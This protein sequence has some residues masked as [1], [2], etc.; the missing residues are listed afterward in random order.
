M[1][2][3]QSSSS[4]CCCNGNFYK[5]INNSAYIYIYIL[6][7]QYQ[8][9]LKYCVN[10]FSHPWFEN[11]RV[12]YLNQAQFFSIYKVNS[13]YLSRDLKFIP[14]PTDTNKYTNTEFKL[15]NRVD[16]RMVKEN[17]L[18]QG[19]KTD[20]AKLLDLHILQNRQKDLSLYF[21]V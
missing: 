4:L 1:H 20:Q 18:P 6:K 15:L 3:R 2:V 17:G 14:N 19:Y 5:P 7:C 13:K 10:Y 11:H 9:Q 21:K 8:S 12:F 16:P